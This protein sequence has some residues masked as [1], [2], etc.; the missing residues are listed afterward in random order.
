MN[1]LQKAKLAGSKE[2][3]DENVNGKPA[4]EDYSFTSMDLIP[5]PVAYI[6]KNSCYEY[7]N[8]AYTEWY[9]TSSE[10]IIGKTTREFL[11]SEIYNRIEDHV[12]KALAGE[13][14]N[15]EIE[16]PRKNGYCF[17]EAF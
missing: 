14:V 2:K 8:K 11:G 5:F 7:V 17:V 1:L 16:I 10:D 4:Y 6:N 13:K 3:G 12:K 15:Y 9:E